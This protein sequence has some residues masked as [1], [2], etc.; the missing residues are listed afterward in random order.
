M[1]VIHLVAQAGVRYSLQN[2]RAY[3]VNLH[4]KNKDQF[5]KTLSQEI[6]IEILLLLNEPEYAY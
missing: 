5:F 1:R 4:E 6:E 3:V 2:P